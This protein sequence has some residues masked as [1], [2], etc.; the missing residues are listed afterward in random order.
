M[1]ANDYYTTTVDDTNMR[2]VSSKVYGTPALHHR[3]R[4][5]N[6][7]VHDPENLHPGTKLAIPRGARRP[8]HPQEP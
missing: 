6:R 4:E 2:Q 5:A 8:R 1:A 7:H 3:L